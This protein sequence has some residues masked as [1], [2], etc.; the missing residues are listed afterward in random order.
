MRVLRNIKTFKNWYLHY[1]NRHGSRKKM[2]DPVDL[3]LRSGLVLRA[4]AKTSDFRTS[5]SIF[6]DESYVRAPIR[7]AED[8]TVLDIGGHIGCFTLFAAERA[9]NGRVFAFEPEPSNFEAL[10]G[11]VERN[12]LEHVKVFNLAVAAEAS[13]REMFR[14]GKAST[15]GANSFFGDKGD[16]FEVHCTTLPD[17][18]EREGIERV[19]FLKLDCEG[20][21]IEILEN[22]SDA[23]LAKIQQIVMEIHYP[24]KMEAI[25]QRLH[26]QGFQRIPHEKKNYGAFWRAGA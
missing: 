11:N 6:T 12:K 5:R 25:F 18:L 22:L 1:W 10:A 21:E 9:R 24:E 19:D 23:D 20:A 2:G 3:K 7:I 8:A 26:E 13:D 16:A 15:T 14:G 4:R 17:I